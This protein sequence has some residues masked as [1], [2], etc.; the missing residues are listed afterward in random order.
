MEYF[1]ATTSTWLP[2]PGTYL[3]RELL[4]NNP[5]T[6]QVRYRA[7]ESRACS[8]P[9][10]VAVPIGPGVGPSAGSFGI[11]YRLEYLT[12]STIS[13][14]MEYSTNGRTWKALPANQL[15]ISSLIPAAT[16][17]ERTIMIRFK[18][19]GGKA[20]S[21]ATEVVIPV[22]PA[23]PM[24]SVTSFN[25]ISEEVI[26]PSGTE[27]RKGTSGAFTAGIPDVT[28]GS[29]SQ[30]YQVRFAAT[31][32]SFA[33][34]VRNVT[35]PARRAA[36]RA[37]Y[38]K[39]TNKITGVSASME[40]SV[41]SATGGWTAITGKQLTDADFGSSATV[42]VRIKATATAPASNVKTVVINRDTPPASTSSLLP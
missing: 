32:G 10:S 33:S 31:S 4:G 20:A 35:V 36:P 2:V 28:V 15:D 18:S 27:Y 40:Y 9:A 19:T 13:D 42:W 8:L 3:S 11:D 30:R 24:A 23:A 29:S 16:S 17:K 12:Y 26:V 34:A 25:G 7:T 37:V 14:P 22:R 6:V 39:T 38:S 21:L 41:V 1:D 5:I